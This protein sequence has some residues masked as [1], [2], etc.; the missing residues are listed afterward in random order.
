MYRI[1]GVKPRDGIPCGRPRIIQRERIKVLMQYEDRRWQRLAQ[2]RIRWCILVLVVWS[3]CLIPP[4][5]CIIRYRKGRQH[6][7][8]V[9]LLSVTLRS[10]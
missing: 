4:G 8:F 7:D 5:N 6:R 2:Y 1:L 9:N 10:E 3:L